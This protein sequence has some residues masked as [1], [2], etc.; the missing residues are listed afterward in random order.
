MKK[1]FNNVVL[2]NKMPKRLIAPIYTIF[3]VGIMAG[4][5]HYAKPYAVDQ[6]NYNQTSLKNYRQ[7]DYML[8][9]RRV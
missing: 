9:I 6:K 4:L 1:L 8:K 2:N 7:S 5:A 3:S